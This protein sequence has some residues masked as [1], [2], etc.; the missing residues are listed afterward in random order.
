V[1]YVPFTERF[2]RIPLVT[3]EVVDLTDADRWPEINRAID[4]ARKLRENGNG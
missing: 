2:G 1:K 4:H 3:E